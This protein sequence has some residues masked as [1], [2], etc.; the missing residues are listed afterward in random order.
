MIALLKGMSVKGFFNFCAIKDL[1]I[2]TAETGASATA[3]AGPELGGGGGA[4]AAGAEAGEEEEGVCALDVGV[5]PAAGA[6]ASSS[7]GSTS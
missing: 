3:A 2:S 6:A 1:T 7:T 5:W 4:A